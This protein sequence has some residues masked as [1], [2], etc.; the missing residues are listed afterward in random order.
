MPG[1]MPGVL[2]LLTLVA[3]TVLHAGCS[4][5]KVITV[6]SDFH[7]LESEMTRVR[8]SDYFKSPLILIVHGGAWEPATREQLDVVNGLY[9]KYKGRGLELFFHRSGRGGVFQTQG[10]ETETGI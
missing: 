8:M 7:A 6:P 9:E 10:P 4:R 2:I 5:K 3:F 1:K